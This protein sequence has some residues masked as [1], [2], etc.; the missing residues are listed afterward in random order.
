MS[1]AV[2]AL[3]A[4]VA[5]PP[6]PAPTVRVPGGSYRLGDARGRYDERPVVSVRLS[7][8]SIDRAEV[9]NAEFERFVRRSGLSPRGPWRR[10]FPAGGGG[11]P[12]RFV[13]WFD[14]DAY[15]RWTGRRLPTEAEWEAAT[16]GVWRPDAA[17]TGR[18]VAAGPVPAAWDGDRSPLGVLNLAL[19]R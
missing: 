16:G 13:A 5:G 11:L 15:C 8:F 17:V 12:V 9:T 1:A 7:P 10:G 18:A 19:T 6:A 3:L 2:L 14:A 4:V